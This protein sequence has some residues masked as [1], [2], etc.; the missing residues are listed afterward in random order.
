MKQ[1]VTINLNHLCPMVTGFTSHIGGPVVGPGCSGVLVDG[2][3]VAV[4]GDACV[5]CGPPDVVVQGYPGVLVDGVPVVVQNCMTAHGGI[6]P[7]GVSGV[8]I[9]ST[10]PMEL[11]TMDVREIPFPEVSF[12]DRIKT[13]VSGQN[14]KLEE[15]IG[16]QE[17]IRKKAE[18]GI[19]NAEPQIYNVRWLRN[20]NIVTDERILHKALIGA[21]TVGFKDDETVTFNVYLKDENGESEQI[22]LSGN[23]K[24]GYVE[25]EWEKIE[26]KEC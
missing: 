22:T 13:I 21:D 19:A 10:T 1:I 12:T 4:M 7:A 17:E 24:D 18:E 3:P 6:I 11:V 25:V 16:N 9:S 20:E 23:V 2:T 26:L 8:V 15:A 5:C 14:R